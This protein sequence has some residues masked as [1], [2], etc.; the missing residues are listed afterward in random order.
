VAGVFGEETAV[1]LPPVWSGLP[2]G[3][4]ESTGERRTPSKKR[5]TVLP[6]LQQAKWENQQGAEGYTRRP[7]V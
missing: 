4:A 5:L 7:V 1:I 6:A 2:A 3:Y